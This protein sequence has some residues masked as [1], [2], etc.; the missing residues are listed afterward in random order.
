MRISLKSKGLKFSLAILAVILIFSYLVFSKGNY[1][2]YSGQE[3]FGTLM[4]LLLDT[5]QSEGKMEITEEDISVLGSSYFKDGVKKGNLTIKGLNVVLGED[6]AKFLIPVKYKGLS[7][8]LTTEGQVAMDDSS[9]VYTPEYFKVG[10][11]NLPK[12]K[13]LGY[14]GGHFKGKMLVEEGKIVV[15]KNILPDDIETFTIKDGKILCTA[16][17]ETRET[18]AKTNETIKKIEEKVKLESGTVLKNLENNAGGKNSST[19]NGSLGSSENNTSKGNSNEGENNS[20]SG[21]SLSKIGGELGSLYGNVSSSK[22]K[23][24][25]SIM[26]GTVNNLQS[27]SSYNFWGDVKSV[28]SIYKSLTPEEKERFKIQVFSNV[29]M[30]NALKLKEELSGN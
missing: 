5:V 28:M 30:E 29:D 24:M 12:S 18:L 3:S 4:S 25:V 8:L 7:V 26:S 9:I 1:K 2:E 23:Q 13:T 21:G 22:E 15:S 11:I 16:K 14:I 10:K 6:K 17:K 20:N 27:D 19:G